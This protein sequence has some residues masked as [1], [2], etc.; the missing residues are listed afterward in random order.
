M[1][2]RGLL[3]YEIWS[4]RTT[5]RIFAV[6]GIF[7]G[8][9]LA[10][11]AFEMF[12]TTPGERVVGSAALAQID[13]L[14]R[15][16]PESPQFDAQSK[17]AEGMVASATKIASAVRDRKI[18]SALGAYLMLV[19]MERDDVEMRKHMQE[20]EKTHPEMIHRFT[21]D[22]ENEKSQSLRTRQFVSTRLHAALDYAGY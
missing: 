13:E 22:E 15:L 14:E 9:F 19:T 20:F 12:W 4:K 11:A 18:A 17:T 16:E 21:S 5:R 1:S 6:S 8:V 10:L 3:H 2:L 7:V